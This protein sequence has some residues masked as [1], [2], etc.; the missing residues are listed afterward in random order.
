MQDKALFSFWIIPL[1]LKQLVKLALLNNFQH[2]IKH[3]ITA[4]LYTG[5]AGEVAVTV[6]TRSIMCGLG[7]VLGLVLRYI[8]QFTVYMVSFTQTPLQRLH[9]HTPIPQNV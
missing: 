2:K 7:I 9:W 6:S 3:A 8:R 4:T 5:C 1:P